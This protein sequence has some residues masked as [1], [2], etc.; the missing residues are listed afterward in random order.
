MTTEQMTGSPYG[1][2]IRMYNRGQDY[3]EIRVIDNGKWRVAAT[4]TD[5]G[6]ADTAARQIRRKL[7]EG[8]NVFHD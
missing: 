1:P 5:L 2:L 4:A 8:E 6:A 3:F 7:M